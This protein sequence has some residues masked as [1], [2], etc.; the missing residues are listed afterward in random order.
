MEAPAA[1]FDGKAYTREELAKLLGVSGAARIFTLVDAAHHRVRIVEE[2]AVQGAAEWAAAN[3][4]RGK[5]PVVDAHV[6]GH[7]LITD[8]AL[9]DKAGA[10][11]A[12]HFGPAEAG[13][14][15]E[16]LEE[17]FMRGKDVVTRWRGL[18]GAGLGLAAAL[19]LAQ[20]TLEFRAQG[21]EEAGGNKPVRIEVVTPGLHRILIGID[22]TDTPEGGATW[23]LARDATAGIEDMA[24]LRQRVVQLFPGVPHKTTNCVASLIEGAVAPWME[25]AVK[26][27]LRDRVESMAKSKEAGVALVE[28]VLIHNFHEAEAFCERA[29][30]GMVTREQADAAARAIK[31]ETP[32]DG[33]G[34]IG[35]VAAI[36]AAQMGPEAADVVK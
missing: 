6:D 27:E 8:A 5:G 13:K 22:D 29:R 14:G 7:T 23:A 10:S 36:G 12:P 32:L 4:K 18:A 33:R 35:A 26:I 34:L 21:L 25:E 11:P 30:G 1:P 2:R 19:G 9:A 15:G 17:C 20:G 24:V 3:R 16:V 28:G 31:A